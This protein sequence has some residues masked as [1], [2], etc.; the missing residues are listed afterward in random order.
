[1]IVLHD[2]QRI[3]RL[4]RLSQILSLAGLG[5]LVLGLLVIFIRNDPNAFLYQLVALAVG[6]VFAQVG[7]HLAHRYLRQPR[8]DEVLDRSA[9]KYAR[10]QNGRMYHYLL[11][12]PHVLLLPSGVVVLNA[13]FQTGNISADGDTWRQTGLGLRRF[14]GR[15]GLGNPTREAE[16]MVAKMNAYIEAN[17]PEAKGAPVWPVIVF[18]AK[19]IDNLDVKGSRIP[20]MH[21]SK[22]ANYLRQN[23]EMQLALPDAMYAS[24]RQAFDVKAA[25]L[26]EE[27]ADE[28]AE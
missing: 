26:I 4:A 13:K 15:E 11:P 2:E 14:F 20:A 10:K 18:T 6:F 9:A 23:R 17:A 1:M 5:V 24:L 21:H 12:A 27:V 28:S 22:L 8:P 16:S 25:N 7:L 3:A 19:S